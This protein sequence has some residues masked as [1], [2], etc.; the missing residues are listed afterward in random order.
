MSAL[1]RERQIGLHEKRIAQQSQQAAEIAGR[2]EEVRIAPAPALD[3]VRANHA[4]SIGA[5]AETAR[6]GRPKETASSI[7]SHGAGNVVA[8]GSHCR[9]R[10]SAA[11][12]TPAPA[13]R[14]Q[15]CLPPRAEPLQ[16]E[17][18]I[19]ISAQQ[20]RL[21][22]DQAGVPHGR[23]PPNSGSTILANIGCTVNSSAALRKSVKREQRRFAAAVH[24]RPARS[25]SLHDPRTL[26]PSRRCALL[27]C[28]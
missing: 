4:W 6:N 26:L 3:R 21:I 19:K 28:P 9:R 27:S 11:K 18:R 15:H 25:R 5:L 8:G 24:H 16:R 20:D 2:I 7:Q 12:S 22:E 10:G 23:A 13:A 17:V 14:V 1:C